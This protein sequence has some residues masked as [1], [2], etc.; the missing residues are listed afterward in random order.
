MIVLSVAAATTFCAATV[1]WKAEAAASSS[2]PSNSLSRTSTKPPV[3]SLS[4]TRLRSPRM[5]GEVVVA[6]LY[7]VD[8]DINPAFR[9][10]T[11]A[12]DDPHF[13]IADRRLILRSRI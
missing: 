6:Q 1:A 11:L 10:N 5:S 9:D 4:L 12:V 3:I 2:K 13:R 8:P 7:I